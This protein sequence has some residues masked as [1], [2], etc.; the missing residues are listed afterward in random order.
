[1]WSSPTG[2]KQSLQAEHE[3]LLQEQDMLFPVEFATGKLPIAKDEGNRS[4]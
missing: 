4:L 2:P 3:D 1:M